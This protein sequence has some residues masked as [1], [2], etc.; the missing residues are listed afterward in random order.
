MSMKYC[1]AYLMAVL[2]GKESP[3]A[4]DIKSI[5]GSVESEFDASV[6]EKLVSELAGKT[7]HEVIKEGKEKLKSFGGGGGGG[8]GAVAAAGGGGGGGAAAEAKKEEKNVVVEEEEED[9]DFDLFG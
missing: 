5:L 6:A 4:D 2:A 3:S 8:G 9:V 1:A 7:V